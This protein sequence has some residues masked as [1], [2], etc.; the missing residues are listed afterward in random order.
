MFDLLSGYEYNIL[1]KMTALKIDHSILCSLWFFYWV[2]AKTYLLQPSSPQ[3]FISFIVHLH[4]ESTQAIGSSKIARYHFIITIL[5]DLH[6]KQRIIVENAEIFQSLDITHNY[7]YSSS[8]L[9]F[10]NFIIL[11]AERFQWIMEYK[12]LF[13]LS[14]TLVSF[15]FFCL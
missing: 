12:D 14:I 3:C 4:S 15:P 11:I 1:V 2:Q 5:T 8:N 7:L 9:V 13:T 10:A 6:R